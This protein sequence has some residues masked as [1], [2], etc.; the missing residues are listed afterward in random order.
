MT[1]ST[2]TFRFCIDFAW[3][4][5]QAMQAIACMLMVPLFP[6]RIGTMTVGEAIVQVT[7]MVPGG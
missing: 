6:Q 1:V 7:G 2:K 4:P 3:E 5:T